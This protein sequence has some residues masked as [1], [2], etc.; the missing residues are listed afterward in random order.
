MIHVA[1]LAL[2]AN[3]SL[4]GEKKNPLFWEKNKNQG[5]FSSLLKRRN[6]T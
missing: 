1:N 2:E 6:N 3:I 5:T 4:K